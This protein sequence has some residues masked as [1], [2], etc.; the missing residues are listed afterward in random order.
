MNHADTPS[1]PQEGPFRTALIAKRTSCCVIVG[2]GEFPSV[3]GESNV[4][5]SSYVGKTRR[6]VRIFTQD[7]VK[8]YFKLEHPRILLTSLADLLK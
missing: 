4:L 6:K 1:G 3:K 5:I 7:L 2:I 8:Q